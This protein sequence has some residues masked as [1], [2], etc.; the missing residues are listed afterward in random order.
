MPL[1]DRL[2]VIIDVLFLKEGICCKLCIVAE[3]NIPEFFE[4]DVQ[5]NGV[6]SELIPVT[7]NGNIVKN[8][9]QV[10]VGWLSKVFINVFELD[11]TILK[12]LGVSNTWF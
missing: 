6:F 11:L 5:Y 12:F 9:E 4:T 2:N 1:G 8:A 7:I 3:V 10:I